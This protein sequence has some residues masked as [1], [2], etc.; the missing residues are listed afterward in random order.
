MR[1]VH[2]TERL[3][4]DHPGLGTIATRTGPTLVIQNDLG[5]TDAHVVVIRVTE[6]VVTITYTDVH[7]ARLLFF[8]E[9]LAA[10][11][12]AGRTRARAATGD[13]GRA[14]PPRERPF[15]GRR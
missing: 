13:R 12:V 9:L 6:R 15:R 7:L 14:L 1:G 4:F 2:S 11:P 8:Q 3:K 5:E 10:W